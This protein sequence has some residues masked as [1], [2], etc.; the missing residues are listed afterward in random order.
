MKLSYPF[1]EQKPA[2]GFALEVAPG[3]K[4]INMPLPFA[5][6]HIN[7]WLL[8][9][10]YE[11]R[12]G[13]TLVDCGIA[14]DPVKEL[15]EQVFINELDGLPVLRV[16]V[17]HMHPD[18]VGLAGWL[19]EKLSVPL[20]MSMT[21]YFVARYWAS[22]PVGGA[23]TGGDVAVKH[24]ARHGLIDAESQEKIRQRAT[25]YP[26]LVSPPPGS[27]NR[28]LDGDT[29]EIGGNTWAL[30]S[31]YGHAPEHIALYSSNLKV[32]ISGDML[33]P[34]ISTNVSVFDH[35]PEG[36]PLPQ[37]LNSLRK[38][39]HL[40]PETLILPSHGRPFKGL[41]ERMKQQHEHHAER[42]VEVLEACR[43]PATVTEI[44]P[45][46]FKRQLDLH[47]LTFAMGEALAHLHA[48]YFEGKVTREL[49]EDGVYR[50]TQKV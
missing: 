24:F 15:W 8:R 3:V 34:R 21:D 41:H 28:L 19:C 26:G 10:T 7:L 14:K 30:I 18:H 44:V 50:F 36:N 46:M 1:G 13:W 4:W 39:E 48:L 45:K 47:Q 49:G 27:F 22:K 42:L 31:G 20:Y 5:L 6:D 37:Y 35:E 12:E 25:Y 16:V 17:T 43:E 33:L 2:A 29:L 40:D 11:G 23:G 9:D 38:F 32:L